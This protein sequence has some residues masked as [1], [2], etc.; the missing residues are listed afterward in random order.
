[1]IPLLIIAL[2]SLSIVNAT[3]FDVEVGKIVKDL[4]YL[5]SKGIDVSKLV[6]QLDRAIKLYEN[7][8]RVEAEKIL[9]NISREVVALKSIANDVAIRILITKIATVA[10]LA[11]IPL[12]VYLLLP[13]AYLYLWYLSRRRWVVEGAER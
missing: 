11:S 13:R 8:N 10:A 9:L 4:E 1:M 7:G 5:E 3:A 6:E 2:T 12:L